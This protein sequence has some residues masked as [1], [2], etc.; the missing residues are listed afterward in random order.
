MVVKDNVFVCSGIQILCHE[1]NEKY[2]I[3]EEKHLV[4]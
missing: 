2:K 4:N 3:K 1:K